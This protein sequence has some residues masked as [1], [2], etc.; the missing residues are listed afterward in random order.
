V[1]IFTILIVAGNYVTAEVVITPIVM[2]FKS[3]LEVVDKVAALR[4]LISNFKYS[5]KYTRIHDGRNANC[6]SMGMTPRLLIKL[7]ERMASHS[8]V[9]LNKVNIYKRQVLLSHIL[10]TV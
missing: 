10:V 1:H 8:G 7:F 6:D 9:L 2:L 3:V 4:E 5:A